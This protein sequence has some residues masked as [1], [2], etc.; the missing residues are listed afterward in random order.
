MIEVVERATSNISIRQLQLR[1]E[2]WPQFG[3]KDLWLRRI[4]NGFTTI[5][6]TMPLILQTM[7]S[8]S[9]GRPVSSV[10]LDLWCRAY[11]ECFVVLNRHQEMAFSAGFTGQ[12]AEQTWMSRISILKDLGFI[13]TQ[14]GPSGPLS[15]AIILNPYKVI[16]RLHAQQAAGLTADLYNTLLAR[17]IEIG[18]DDLVEDDASNDGEKTKMRKVTKTPKTNLAV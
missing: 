11:D 5:P 15:Y 18:A 1:K 7:D 12:R 14:P 6:R 10:Y 8:L 16:K 9:K 17:S 3:S 4:R 2:L 13:A